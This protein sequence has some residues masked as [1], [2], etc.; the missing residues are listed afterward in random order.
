[1]Q[2][3][4]FTA[5]KELASL[6]LRDKTAAKKYFKRNYYLPLI[7]NRSHPF[8]SSED[9]FYRRD[10]RTKEQYIDHQKAKRGLVESTLNR[11]FDERVDNFCRY[12]FHITFPSRPSASV[13]CL[14]ARDGVEVAALRRLGHL[15]VGLDIEYPANSPYVHFGD[16]HSLPYP[17]HCF[18][19]VY[20]NCFDHVFDP[21]QLLAEIRRVLKMKDGH[22]LL[23]IG[24]GPDD[25]ADGQD[26]GARG[27]FE[28]FGWKKRRDVIALI[29]K[30]GF[31]LAE[32]HD[33]G[34]LHKFNTD[35]T[36]Y[37]FGV[38]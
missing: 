1:M 29:E 8:R 5:V 11:L 17:D 37:L 9:G 38:K 24:D 3:N 28:S 20:M 19:F 15:A 35:Y 25:R 12:R 14:G 33:I 23:D 18:D 31:A 13:L 36:Q 4:L 34:G 32:T 2:K 21:P 16:F 6:Y 7:Y 10:Y 26:N 22:F 27:T 30:N